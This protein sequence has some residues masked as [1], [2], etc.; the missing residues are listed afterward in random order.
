[1]R[2]EA[3]RDPLRSFTVL[4]TLNMSRKF[5]IEMQSRAVAKLSARAAR[6]GVHALAVVMSVAMTACG[7]GSDPIAPIVVGTLTISPTAPTVPESRTTKL[8]VV[9]KATNG[10][11]LTDRVVKWSSASVATATINDSGIVTGVQTGSTT[12]TATSEGVSA[13]VLLNVTVGPCSA[14]LAK[15][16]VSGVIVNGTLATSDCDFEDGTFVDAYSFSL[17]SETTLD[18]LM[19]SNAFDA[20]LYVLKPTA[21]DFETVGNDNNSGGGMDARLTGKL[22]AGN[23]FI[24]AN[25]N[26]PGLGAYTLLFTSPFAELNAGIPLF[27]PRSNAGINFRSVTSAEARKLRKFLRSR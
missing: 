17:A 10:S 23:Y 8:S 20:Y 5:T 13:S 16:I 19:R 14:S 3:E 7:G 2:R 4:T 11:V 22:P 27:V 1:M 25:S 18:I 26:E 21:A 12:I 9:V 24:L 6:C 15:P